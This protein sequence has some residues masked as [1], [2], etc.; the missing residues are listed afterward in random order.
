MSDMVGRLL[1]TLPILSEAAELEHIEHIGYFIRRGSL[2]TDI[3][4]S[5]AEIT[6]I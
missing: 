1:I 5:A 4:G 2:F 3:V 6:V